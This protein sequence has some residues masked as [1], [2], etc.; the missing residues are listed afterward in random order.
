MNVISTFINPLAPFH[1]MKKHL[2]VQACQMKKL[3]NFDQC[4]PL[5]NAKTYLLFHRILSSSNMN[6]SDFDFNFEAVYQNPL[7]HSSAHFDLPT[8]IKSRI[9]H[10]GVGNGVNM[11][12]LPLEH[13]T[14]KHITLRLV[15][16]AARI[17]DNSYRL[18]MHLLRTI[19]LRDLYY[20]L[21][22]ALITALII[23]FIPYSLTI[24]PFRS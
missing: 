3:K 2:L 21:C 6:K 16:F 19:T 1:P 7:V 14:I 15:G 24:Q 23:L 10:I 9:Y 17:C 12:E 4:Q 20:G 22:F 13:S 8:P 11:I 18:L 5:N